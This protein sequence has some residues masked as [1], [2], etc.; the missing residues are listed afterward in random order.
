MQSVT[1]CNIDFWKCLKYLVIHETPFLFFGF[2]N[3]THVEAPFLVLKTVVI[4]SGSLRVNTVH[5]STH[6]TPQE[7]IGFWVIWIFRE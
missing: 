2:Q 5:V 7:S 3:Y 1:T 6:R 4:F